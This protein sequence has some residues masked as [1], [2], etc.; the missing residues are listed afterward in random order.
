[1]RGFVYAIASILL[2][3]LTITAIDAY[4]VFIAYPLR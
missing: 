1:M 3:L 2:A 4:I